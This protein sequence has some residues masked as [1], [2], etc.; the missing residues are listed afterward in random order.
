MLQIKQV[1]ITHKRD[2][3]VLVENFSIVL[4]KGDKAAIIGEEGNG[5]STL[6]KWLYNP[7]SIEEYAE[8][9]GFV[10]KKGLKF[11]YLPQELDLEQKEKSVYSFFA[12]CDAFFNCTPKDLKEISF[13]LGLKQTIFYDEQKIKTLSGGEKIKIQ[14]A[15]LFMEHCDVYLLDEPSNDLDIE[16]LKWLEQFI[17]ES[18]QPVLF[19]SHDETLLENTANVIIHLELVRRKT[20]PRVS[21]FRKSYSLYMQERALKIEKQTKEAAGERRQI[22]KQMEKF[23]QIEAKVEHRQNTVSR[24]DPHSGQLLKKKMKA[25]KSMEH[26]FERRQ[27]QMTQFP[28]VE[29]SIFL[30]FDHEVFVPCGKC[31]LDLKIPILYAEKNLVS[32]NIHLTVFGGEKVCITGRNGTGKSTLLK[33]IVRQLRSRTDIRMFYMPQD[34]EEL[35]NS[36]DTPLSFLSESKKKDELTKVRTLLGSLKYTQEEM[37]HPIKALSGGQ[38]AK[39]FFVKMILQKANVLILDE[40]TRNFSPLSNPVVRE[41]LCSYRGTVISVSH[42]RKY[43]KD[44]CT[45]TY[46]MD[47]TGLHLV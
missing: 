38:K 14:L 2:L 20:V 18:E 45:K 17:S 16:T 30:K 47:E 35:L 28:E 29:E 21:V 4:Q 5:K 15:K 27:E 23:R 9:T 36:E 43:M 12:D 7:I 41:V 40:P 34:Y 24:Q 26:N 39:L 33:E 1:T 6:L 11:G 25:V 42:D 31:V 13:R 19:I 10:Y 8:G 32:E 3:R 22:D 44:V 37:M 46:M